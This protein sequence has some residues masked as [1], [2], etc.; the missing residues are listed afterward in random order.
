M[1]DTTTDGVVLDVAPDSVES[2]IEAPCASLADNES[3]KLVANTR[4]PKD[5]PTALN[6]SAQF[7][8][9]LREYRKHNLTY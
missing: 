3:V 2:S 1:E 4:R 8:T 6:G 9:R 5:R 7:A